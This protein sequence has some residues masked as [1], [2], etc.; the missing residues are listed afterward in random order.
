MLLK[1]QFV[2]KQS[3]MHCRYCKCLAVTFSVLSTLVYL[4]IK[5]AG[6]TVTLEK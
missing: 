6:R 1:G 5:C 4:G 2:T 3:L